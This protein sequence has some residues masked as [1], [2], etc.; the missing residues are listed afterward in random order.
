MK[1]RPQ[2]KNRA[3]KEIPT[4][5]HFMGPLINTSPNT[6]RKMAIAPMYIGPAVNACSPQYKGNC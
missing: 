1:F 2:P 6:K 5:H 3:S 4:I